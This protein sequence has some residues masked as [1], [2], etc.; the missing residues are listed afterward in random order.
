MS[1][2]LVP[3]RPSFGLLCLELWSLRRDG[4]RG[5]SGGLDSWRGLGFVLLGHIFGKA[6]CRLDRCVR[7][8]GCNSSL[9]KISE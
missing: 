2:F 6:V 7:S 8:L 1:S 9:M 4:W 3:G 5:G